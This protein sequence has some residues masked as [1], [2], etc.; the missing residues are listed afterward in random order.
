MIN[1]KI[2]KWPVVIIASPR[3]GSTALAKYL[4]DKNQV[5]YFLEPWHSSINR[6]LNWEESVHG[7]KKNFYDFYKNK[8]HNKYLLKIFADQINCFTP[9]EEILNSC[10]KIRLTRENV[11]DQHV[12]RYISMQN[13][14][15]RQDT[16]EKIKPYTVE[17]DT[18][19]MLD[20]IAAN[21]NLDYLIRNLNIKW[22]ADITYESLDFTQQGRDAKTY[23]PTNLEEIRSK[24]I[25]IYN[26][27]DIRVK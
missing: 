20:C 22:D 15:W 10:F 1:L 4:A 23:P 27:I 12:S 14:K 19:I 9:Y 25:E 17:I 16:N 3:T 7:V 13:N 11:I 6:G 8:E 2:T 5:P 24:I 18:N 21:S 26:S